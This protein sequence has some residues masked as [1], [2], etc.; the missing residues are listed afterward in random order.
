MGTTAVKQGSAGEYQPAF[1]ASDDHSKG[2]G[3]LL[4]D[5]GESSNETGIGSKDGRQSTAHSTGVGCSEQESNDQRS[6]SEGKRDDE[7]THR[8]NHQRTCSNQRRAR[9]RALNFTAVLVLVG[10]DKFWPS[11]LVLVQNVD[12]QI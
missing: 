7:R 12:C 1:P 3:S 9:A 8:C 5:N 2:N 10:L 11:R 4:S 6:E